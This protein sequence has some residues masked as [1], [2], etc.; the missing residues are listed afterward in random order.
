LSIP[1]M[2]PA[3]ELADKL[4]I[5]GNSKTTSPLKTGGR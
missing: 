3:W 2:N 4:R 5:E 1:T